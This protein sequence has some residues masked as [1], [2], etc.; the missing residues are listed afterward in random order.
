ML[1]PAKGGRAK[2]YSAHYLPEIFSAA[3]YPNDGNITIRRLYPIKLPAT[4]TIVRITF[5]R[6]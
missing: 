6:Y 2:T 4:K 3:Y 1:L 5:H